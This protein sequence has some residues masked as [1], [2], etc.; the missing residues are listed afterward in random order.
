MDRKPGRRRPTWFGNNRHAAHN[1]PYPPNP[2]SAS[3]PPKQPN[4]LG[5]MWQ[6]EPGGRM[7]TDSWLLG[8]PQTPDASS[9]RQPGWEP[10]SNLPELPPMLADNGFRARSEI[11]DRYNRLAPESTT[12]EHD[13]PLWVQP[14]ALASSGAP[15]D[16][17]TDARQDFP[18]EGRLRAL[19]STFATR[20]RRPRLALGVIAGVLA[21]CLIF[22]I[23]ALGNAV[24]NAFT[25]GSPNSAHGVLGT[26]SAAATASP[27]AGHA[28]PGATTTTSASSATTATPANTQPPTPLT[29]AFTCASG[30]AGGTGK[31]CVH[32]LPHASLSLT[33]RYCDGSYAKGK[34]FHGVSYAD[35]NGDYTW[36]WT[37]TTT[38]IGAATATVTATSAGK[39]VTSAT[40]FTITR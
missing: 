28:T 1:A 29:I 16:I 21:V 20:V 13:A 11:A 4:T 17:A 6:R 2:P 18:P 14:D 24:G 5:R 8:E 30:V 40:T 3:A 15:A 19:W 23:A 36:S 31:V 26:G 27:S 39:T 9:P 33:V 12:D 25:Q 7:D 10:L 32:T 34:A 38:C 35:S 22:G 37:V